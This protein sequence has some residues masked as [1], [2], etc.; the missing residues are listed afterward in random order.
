MI[1]LLADLHAKGLPDQTLELLG[2]GFGR[3]AAHPGL[4]TTT[5]GINTIMW[6][7]AGLESGASRR[8]ELL[9]QT[10][11]VL[12]RGHYLA[13]GAVPRQSTL[14]LRFDVPR[15][16]TTQ[17]AAGWPDPGASSRRRRSAERSTFR[18]PT[19]LT[20]TTPI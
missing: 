12:A 18:R 10:L 11:V 9:D 4:T 8:M 3:S 7:L 19:T 2:T 16:A 13:F 6:L 14:T 5:G 20:A 1:A 15:L 17:I